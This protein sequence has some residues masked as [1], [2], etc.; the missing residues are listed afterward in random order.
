MGGE[1]G[2][3]FANCLDY[4]RLRAIT[5]DHLGRYCRPL[6]GRKSAYKNCFGRYAAVKVHE[7][8]RYNIL[9]VYLYAAASDVTLMSSTGRIL[10]GRRWKD[11]SPRVIVRRP[12]SWRGRWRRRLAVRD[13]WVLVAPLL[14]LRPVLQRHAAEPRNAAV[15]GSPRGPG[16]LCPK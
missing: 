13:K 10:H 7:F 16:W 2:G 15:A 3:E 6:S 5:C 8:L 1:G 12:L 11:I 14:L 4:V 9:K